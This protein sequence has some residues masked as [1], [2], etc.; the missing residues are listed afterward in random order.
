[1]TLKVQNLKYYLIKQ[2]KNW[3]LRVC[4]GTT[5]HHVPTHVTKRLNISRDTSTSRN[6]APCPC[7]RKV[8]M[9][10]GKAKVT[11]YEFA[12]RP[13]RNVSLLGKYA[14]SAGN[15]SSNQGV[16]LDCLKSEYDGLRFFETSVNIYQSTLYSILEYFI[17]QGQ[18]FF[19]A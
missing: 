12:Q 4:M 16:F 10:V 15:S 9:W 3:D 17:L 11:R 19:H 18:R 8:K 7:F 14:V 5:T 2:K 13:W 1:M 6:G